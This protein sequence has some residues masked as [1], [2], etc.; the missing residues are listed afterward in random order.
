MTI[1]PE[2]VGNIVSLKLPEGQNA[3][4]NSPEYFDNPNSSFLLE[5]DAQVEVTF[6]HEGAGFKN[7]LG[8]YTY[9]IS[10]PPSSIDELDKII[11]F[12]N[13]S[14]SGS[15][16]ELIPGNTVEVLGTFSE[17]TVFGFYLVSYG[18]R[19]ELTDGFYTQYSDWQFNENN[20]QQNLIFYDADCDAFVLCFEDAYCYLEVTK[21]SMM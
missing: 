21:I 7:T 10:S 6:L 14:A 5:S 1:A 13:S 20:L 3:L 11:I 9:N 8:Y 2:V 4:I 16:G 12:P 18:W 17:G 15:G 19:N